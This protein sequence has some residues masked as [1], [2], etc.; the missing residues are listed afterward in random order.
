MILVD[1]RK[2]APGTIEA[3]VTC[4]NGYGSPNLNKGVLLPHGLVPF[5]NYKDL[6]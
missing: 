1:S 5:E 6:P 2:C 3:Y 4:H